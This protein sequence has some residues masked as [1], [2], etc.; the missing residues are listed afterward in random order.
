MQTA[1]E[2]M[3]V[4]DEFANGESEMTRGRGEFA[5][6]KGQCVAGDRFRFYHRHGAGTGR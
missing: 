4:C 3:A 6:S 1:K 5:F 2:K